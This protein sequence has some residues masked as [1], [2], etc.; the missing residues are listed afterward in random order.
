MV[1]N[2]RAFIFLKFKDAAKI[3]HKV[4]VSNLSSRNFSK[5]ALQF[6]V[7]KRKVQK[8]RTEGVII[9]RKQ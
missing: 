4:R 5:E 7:K 6:F 1:N 3:W 9:R 2:T 8:S